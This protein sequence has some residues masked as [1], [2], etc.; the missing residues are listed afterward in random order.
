[1]SV[2]LAQNKLSS[3]K[4][5]LKRGGIQT[6]SELMEMKLL[7]DLH[8]DANELQLL[9]VAVDKMRLHRWLVDKG[10]TNLETQL[11]HKD[12]L[13]LKVLAEM[14]QN[15]DEMFKGIIWDGQKTKFLSAIESLNPSKSN[16]PSSHGS[17]SSIEGNDSLLSDMIN[18]YS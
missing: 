5:K 12:I 4:D 16:E 14:S 11:H 6:T 2:W 1:M 13:S 7:T 9:T 3:I 17:S 18:L 8:L 15:K 10:L